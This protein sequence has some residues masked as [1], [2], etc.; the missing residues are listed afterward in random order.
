[1]PH[2]WYFIWGNE[3]YFTFDIKC[4]LSSICYLY[5]Y[6]YNKMMASKH[7]DW[8][9]Y[10]DTLDL[11]WQ[12][13]F[14][15][16]IAVDLSLY[17]CQSYCFTGY[18]VTFTPLRELLVSVIVSKWGDRYLIRQNTMPP[19]DSHRECKFNGNTYYV[20]FRT[21]SDICWAAGWFIVNIKMDYFFHIAL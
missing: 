8:Q 13:H 20:T 14:S 5:L 18:I 4:F 15:D 6:Q 12:H 11:L 9:V 17:T 19:L 7:I 3:N 2:T 10:E 16:N 1:M 21:N